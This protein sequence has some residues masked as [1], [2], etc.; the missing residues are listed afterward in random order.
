ME[1]LITG[2]ELKGSRSFHKL[3]AFGED[4]ILIL[5]VH[6]ATMDDDELAGFLCKTDIKTLWDLRQTL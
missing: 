3:A 1:F 2:L 6:N 4:D 5:R